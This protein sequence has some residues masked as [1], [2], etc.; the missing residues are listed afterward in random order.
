LHANKEILEAEEAIFIY[1]NMPITTL[2]EIATVE[3]LKTPAINAKNLV[4]NVVKKAHFETRITSRA[5]EI[6][7]TK[8]LIKAKDAVLAY[9]TKPIT[10]LT[11]IYIAEG[12]KASTIMAVSLLPDSTEKTGLQTRITDKETAIKTQKII[13]KEADLNNT[14][15]HIL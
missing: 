4:S 2:L 9:E 14:N 1:E 7:L 5:N 3:G 8:K 15:S 12:L 11:E 6:D 13:L 10:T